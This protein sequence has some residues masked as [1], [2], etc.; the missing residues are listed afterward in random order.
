MANAVAAYFVSLD[1]AADRSAD[2]QHAHITRIP[3]QVVAN[4]G[5]VGAVECDVV[6]T[7]AIRAGIREARG[8]RAQ[9]VLLDDRAGHCPDADIGLSSPGKP[10]VG[11]AEDREA[12]DRCFGGLD[13]EPPRDVKSAVVELHLRT[14]DG[15]KNQ[16]VHANHAADAQRAGV[17]I[18]Y[19]GCLHRAVDG[20][21]RVA[22]RRQCAC[23]CNDRD[24]AGQ[25]ASQTGAKTGMRQA[26]GDHED[27][28]L[29]PDGLACLGETGIAE[30]VGVRDEL[31]QRTLAGVVDIDDGVEVETEV[32]A[33]EG[34]GCNDGR[35]RLGL[36]ADSRGEHTG[37]R[38]HRRAE[39]TRAGIAHRRIFTTHPVRIGG[40]DRAGQPIGAE[41]LHRQQAGDVAG[42]RA[43][44]AAVDD[45]DG[46]VAV[47]QAEERVTARCVRDRAADEVS[48]GVVEFDLCIRLSAAAGCRETASG[49]A[50]VVHILEHLARNAGRSHG[51]DHAAELGSVSRQ[52]GRGGQLSSGAHPAR[53]RDR[54]CKPLRR[55]RALIEAID[56]ARVGAGRGIRIRRRA[57]GQRSQV[58]LALAESASVAIADEKLD[59]RSGL[60]ESG[61]HEIASDDAGARKNRKVQQ[62]VAS[63]ARTGGV[64]C[65]E[66]VGT[67]I[68]I[69]GGRVQVDADLRCRRGAE[70][71]GNRAV[72]ENRVL[73][74]DST[75]RTVVDCKACAIVRG[76]P[77]AR[78]RV[79]GSRAANRDA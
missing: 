58:G 66:R 1:Q 77:V 55:V 28:C 10:V 37:R 15:G 18:A 9:H 49:T 24:A 71:R 74:N 48:A 4:D 53:H 73:R 65:V 30:R 40:A 68:G 11:E 70:S 13:V 22:D 21:A 6:T 14:V 61:Q 44:D 38:I 8:R 32:D 5:A 59:D 45:P 63:G 50:T 25:L 26:V 2:E 3:D 36:A 51:R 60:C 16:V 67:E 52:R 41:G 17:G 31:A 46:V 47:D 43:G 19:I 23:H 57:F 42:A 35:D 20:R 76:N 7:C 33:G 62:A 39:R 56:R 72:C 29:A 54:E 12:A 78:D 75:A 64:G 27:R 79:R 69:F 34:G